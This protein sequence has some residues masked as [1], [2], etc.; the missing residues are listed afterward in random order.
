MSATTSIK[1][2]IRFQVASDLHEHDGPYDTS[3]IAKLPRRRLPPPPRTQGPQSAR[4][5]PNTARPQLSGLLRLP[6]AHV[7]EVQSRNSG[8]QTL[9]PSAVKSCPAIFPRIQNNK[10]YIHSRVVHPGTRDVPVCF[11]PSVVEM[12]RSGTRAPLRSL[13]PSILGCTLWSRH[14]EDHIN[15]NVAS[16]DSAIRSAAAS[17]TWSVHS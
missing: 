2:K 17:F 13:L 7:P 4:K 10:T 6:R 8:P 1:R 14:R 3:D 12:W 9:H 16:F 11:T 5:T 15:H